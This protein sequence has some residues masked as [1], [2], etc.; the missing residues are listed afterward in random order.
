MSKALQPGDKAPAFKT[1]TVGGTY[2]N[3]ETVKLA[4]FK[5]RNVI[6]YF[7][8]KDDTPGC[9]KQACGLRD[10]WRDFAG[11]AAVFGRCFNLFPIP[12]IQI[13]F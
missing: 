13:K 8:P 7:Y 6:L 2:G 1:T 11:K 10:A 12:V 4:D 3:G 9:T 5:G